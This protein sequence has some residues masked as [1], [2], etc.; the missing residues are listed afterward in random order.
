M[1]SPHALEAWA[2]VR[3]ESMGVDGVF[4]PY[5]IGMLG[6]P[7]AVTG[8]SDDEVMFSVHQVL[9]G[10]LSPEDEVC[11]AGGHVDIAAMEA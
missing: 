8:D 2:T 10:W 1:G 6:D 5:V 7:D 4:A 9:M 3:L 11:F